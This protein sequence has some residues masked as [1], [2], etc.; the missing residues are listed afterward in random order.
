MTRYF[1]DANVAGAPVPDRTGMLL[2]DRDE[3][4]RA[5]LEAIGVTALDLCLA[6]RTGTV[7]MTIRQVGS[8]VET[9]TVSISA[10]PPV[11]RQAHY[12]AS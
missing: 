11:S 3:A 2:S 8:T 9:I 7:D 4:F 5:A 10:M 6:G 12:E 1:F